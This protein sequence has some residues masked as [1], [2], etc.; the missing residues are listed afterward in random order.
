LILALALTAAGAAAAQTTEQQPKEARD[1][2]LA[3]AAGTVGGA[4]VGAAVGSLFGGGV[5]KSLF[6]AAGAG[7]GIAGGRHLECR[8]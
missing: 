4:V 7:L 5:G 6:E 3:C 2:E 1:H 8:R